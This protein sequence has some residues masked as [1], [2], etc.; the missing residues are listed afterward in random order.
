MAILVS[1]LKV[2]EF[3]D[4]NRNGV[5]DENVDSIVGTPVS[6]AAQAW[7]KVCYNSLSKSHHPKIFNFT[8]IP[9]LDDSDRRGPA[10]SL[11]IGVPSIGVADGD[12]SDASA[13]SVQ[14][15]L[16]DVK[17]TVQDSVLGLLVS[18]KSDS[19]L[20]PN[21]SVVEPLELVDDR[22][23]RTSSD[24]GAITFEV[25]SGNRR[26]FVRRIASAKPKTGQRA[27]LS[28]D[29]DSA[30]PQ[31]L[32][33]FGAAD[34]SIIS[35]RL[36]YSPSIIDQPVEIQQSVDTSY[37]IIFASACLGAGGIIVTSIVA[38]WCFGYR[39]QSAYE[40]IPDHDLGSL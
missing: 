15:V 33:S 10:F 22:V 40:R 6:L 38:Y 11:Q 12:D 8:T 29:G 37:R 30:D 32:V 2:L 7:D 5:F 23:V 9:P 24:Y 18:I 39:M 4:S 20:S 19:G 34:T 14:I 13:F 17:P 28:A 1:F 25:A 26:P 36:S 31:F 35:A 3:I 21:T 27:L 16:R